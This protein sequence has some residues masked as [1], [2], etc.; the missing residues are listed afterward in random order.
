MGGILGG[1]SKVP[2]EDPAVKAAREKA[3]A[4]AAAEKERLEKAKREEESARAR[5]LRGRSALL[6]KEGGELGFPAK[7]GG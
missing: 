2:A 1:G 7:L 3:A 4:D 5:G 6:S